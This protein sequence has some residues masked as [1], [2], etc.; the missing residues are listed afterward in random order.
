MDSFQGLLPFLIAHNVTVQR[1]KPKE[2]N[3]AYANDT[4]GETITT[5]GLNKTK[6]LVPNRGQVQK[7]LKQRALSL[8]V[9]TPFETWHVSQLWNKKTRNFLIW[10]AFMQI[11]WLAGWLVSP[12]SRSE[13]LRWV[14][15]TRKT[16]RVVERSTVNVG[17]LFG[18]S[19]LV[20]FRSHG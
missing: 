18:S 17:L 5:S 9:R 14:M 10:N 11:G 7:Q 13:G 1:N 6:K 12:P 3:I 4:K 2:I 16:R 8:C 15:W 19:S 20:L